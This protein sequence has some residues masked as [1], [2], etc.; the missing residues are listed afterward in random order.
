MAGERSISAATPPQRTTRRMRERRI[1]QLASRQR[2]IVTS[3][4]LVEAGFAARTVRDRAA[5]GRL[6]RLFPGTWAV[7]PP[8][9]SPEQIALAAVLACGGESV[10]SSLSA[11]FLLGMRKAAPAVVHVTNPT[12]AGRKIDGVVA[13]RGTVAPVDRSVRRK[14]PCTTA[15][16][17][18]VDLAAVLGPEELEEALLAADA[19]RLLNRRRLGELLEQ[20]RG[21][22]GIARL[23]RILGHE[24]VDTRSR[25]ER[26]LLV[27]CRSAGLR[28]P[29]A[30]FRI[31]VGARSFVADLCWPEL[32]L[33]VEAD[34]WRWHGGRRAS[35]RDRD[36]E[37]LLAAEG[38]ETIRFTREAIIGRPDET[39][40]RLRAI[41]ASRA[42]RA[43]PSS[44][45]RRR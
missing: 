34:G 27:L 43:D 35:E 5:A 19:K 33:I 28:P 29:R 14:V 38:W 45:P 23:R 40:E 9:H 16:R 15:A 1:V 21:A 32:R 17:T 41:L 36:R 42:E 2:Q 10:V 18:I 25:P 44:G 20:H 24:R 39:V 31:R 37:G 6:F 4:Q 30:N 3:T 8:P 7:H 22:R 12:G 26:R 13:H 11:A